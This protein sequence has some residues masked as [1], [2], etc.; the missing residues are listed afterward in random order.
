MT[1]SKKRIELTITLGEGEFGDTAGNTVTITGA[2]I[3]AD[4]AN[5]GGETMGAAQIRVYGISES[6]M[7]KLTTIGQINRAVR[8]KNT[9]AVAA[10]DDDTGMQLAFV[11]V[12]V[13]AWADYNA[14]PE[15]PFMIQAYAGM[16]VAVK[17]V[18]AT[19]YRGST[20]VIQIL[21]DL[22]GEAGVTLDAED[23]EVQLFNPYFPGATLNK[24]RDVCRA[25]GLQYAIDRSELRV[26][27]TGKSAV[28]D[29]PL[30]SAGKNMIGYPSLSSKGMTVQCRFN[31]NVKIGADIEVESSL[32]MANGSWHVFTTSH[33]ISSVADGGP[34]NTKI[35]AYRVEP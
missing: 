26:W 13:D 18:N 10:G 35:E 22:A 15:V 20:P 32:P 17:P 1:F 7:N 2:K 24:I 29:K 23:P 34:W 12:I 28:G 25:A 8:T 33:N 6:L 3:F 30:I 16:D 5:P 27:K 11:G 21:V 31:P 4:L 14:Q 9:V 19:A